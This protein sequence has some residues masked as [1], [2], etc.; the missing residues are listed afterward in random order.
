MKKG[1]PK[2]Y[3]PYVTITYEELGDYVGRRSIV[4]VSKAW[5][6]DV[7]E[8]SADPVPPQEVVSTPQTLEVDDKIEFKLTDL[9]ND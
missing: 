6:K 4:T 5:W 9:N 1:R 3:S 7:R 2:G 8:S